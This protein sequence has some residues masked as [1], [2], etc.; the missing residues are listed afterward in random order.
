MRQFKDGG[1]LERWMVAVV[2]GSGPPPPPEMLLPPQEFKIKQKGGK[3]VKLTIGVT[4]VVISED[5]KKSKEIASHALG[6][7][8][9]WKVINGPPT[10]FQF[11][12]APTVV[13]LQKSATGALAFS[14]KLRIQR[15]GGNDWPENP[16]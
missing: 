7:C 14:I 1:L 5:N 13:E 16:F 3:K 6:S 12:V 11:A 2:A 9:G 8:S 4:R 15:S 10:A